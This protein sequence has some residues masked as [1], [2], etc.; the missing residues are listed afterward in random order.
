[1]A[2]DERRS[3][4]ILFGGVDP[5]A[6]RSGR[7]WAWSGAEWTELAVANAPSAREGA[8]LVYDSL[9]SRMLL[10]GGRSDTGYLNDVWELRGSQWSQLTNAPFQG[11]AKLSAAYDAARDRLVVFGGTNGTAFADTWEYDG[12]SWTQ[13][14]PIHAPTA[15]AGAGISYNATQGRVTLFGGLG[16]G[17][18][19]DAWTWDGADWTLIPGLSPS[20]RSS[21]AQVFDSRRSVTRVAHRPVVEGLLEWAHV[22]GCPPEP[23][24]APLPCSDAGLAVERLTW[25]PGRAGSE[26]VFV[27]IAGGGHTW[28]GRR[29]DSFF[30]GPSALS[31]DANLLIW[32]FFTRHP[33]V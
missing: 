33:L 30:L 1:M 28:P 4:A 25:G 23:V 7:T 32:E 31:L 3:V 14:F 19:G 21:H 13:A 18:L 9:R 26:V 10:I 27:R 2:F 15:R 5:T 20:P 6:R 29:P 11:R 12:A 16:A 22:N 24:R 17:P 8:G